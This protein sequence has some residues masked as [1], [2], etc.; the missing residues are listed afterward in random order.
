MGS[1]GLWGSMG[2]SRRLA[3]STMSGAFAV[4]FSEFRQARPLAPPLWARS[5]H[6]MSD[7]QECQQTQNFPSFQNLVLNVDLDII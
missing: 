6:N 5:L 1:V 7:K 3:K 4:V 2:Y